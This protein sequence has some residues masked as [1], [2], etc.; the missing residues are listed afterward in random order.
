[1]G[2]NAHKLRSRVKF[3]GKI[4]WSLCSEKEVVVVNKDTKLP[5]TVVAN[6]PMLLL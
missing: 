6:L 4:Q 3:E 1:M 2:K 5:V